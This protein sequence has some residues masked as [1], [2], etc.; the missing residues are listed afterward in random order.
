VDVESAQTLLSNVDHSAMDMCSAATNVTTARD[1][2][3]GALS[4]SPDVVT[5]F[6]GFFDEREAAPARIASR[7][8][9][10][11]DAVMEGVTAIVFGDDEMAT[12]MA[13]GA[14]VLLPVAAANPFSS[15]R[16]GAQP[17]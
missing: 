7:I 3:L 4:G 13:P 9:R 12:R 17:K 15:S 8:A 16:F 1:T 14:G 5:A 11:A 10:S 6:A 2:I